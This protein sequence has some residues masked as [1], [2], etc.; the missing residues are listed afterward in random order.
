MLFAGIFFL[1]LPVA[2]FGQDQFNPEANAQNAATYFDWAVSK[3]KKGNLSGAMADYDQAIKLNPN[4][5]NAYNN[6]WNP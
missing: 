3:E 4:F 6:R 5:S 2:A 1:M